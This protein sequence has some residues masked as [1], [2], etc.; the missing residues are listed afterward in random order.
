MPECEYL[1]ITSWFD[2]LVNQF[3]LSVQA[4]GEFI[5]P[6]FIVRHN[7]CEKCT[8]IGRINNHNRCWFSFNRNE[9]ECIHWWSSIWIKLYIV[10]Y[11][12][13]VYLQSQPSGCFH[14]LLQRNRNEESAVTVVRYSPYTIDNVFV[15]VNQYMLKHSGN[16][17]LLFRIT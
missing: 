8:S 7:K 11:V 16:F 9:N 14:R 2:W 10:Y 13:S 4:V 1:V 3:D 15:R 6:A 5:I 17:N 12:T